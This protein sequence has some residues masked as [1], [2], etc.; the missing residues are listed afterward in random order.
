MAPVIA[1]QREIH[2][3]VPPF[4][5]TFLSLLKNFLLSLISMVLIF[6]TVI[7]ILNSLLRRNYFRNISSVEESRL[8][9]HLSGN[10]SL[11]LK[12]FFLRQSYLNLP[13]QD[14]LCI[15]KEEPQIKDLFELPPK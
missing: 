11:D 2:S 15:S 10:P 1:V 9:S 4:R 12:D 14:I 7:L 13:G 5:R 6:S 3:F 8:L